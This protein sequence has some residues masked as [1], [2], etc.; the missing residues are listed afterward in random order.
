MPGPDG[1]SP[2]YLTTVGKQAFFSADYPDAG[3]ELWVSNCTNKG[4]KLVKDI[5]PG[6]GD[7]DP[8]WLTPAD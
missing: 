8:Q 4:T 3:R 7:A 1:S 6:V 5:Y 2:R